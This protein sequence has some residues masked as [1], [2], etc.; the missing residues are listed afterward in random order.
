MVGLIN[1]VGEGVGRREGLGV[2][3]ARG[4]W[5]GIGDGEPKAARSIEP[6]GIEFDADSLY[7]TVGWKVGS[8]L[9]TQAIVGS[10]DGCI[11]SGTASKKIHGPYSKVYFKLTIKLFGD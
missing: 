9:G 1:S 5:E 10:K 6:P 11:A 4:F 3:W 7:S 8:G 2:G